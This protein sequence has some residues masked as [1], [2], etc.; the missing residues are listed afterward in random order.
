[1]PNN[2]CTRI[3]STAYIKNEIQVIP[4]PVVEPLPTI[5][6]TEEFYDPEVPFEEQATKRTE[7]FTNNIAAS[8]DIFSTLEYPDV[9]ETECFAE[10]NLYKQ[11]NAFD[12]TC[13]VE[14]EFAGEETSKYKAIALAYYNEATKG[15][16]VAIPEPEL[17][18]PYSIRV[19]CKKNGFKVW[20]YK[21]LSCAEPVERA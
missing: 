11:A 7:Q 9:P 1:M 16:C 14:D 15:S 4:A 19:E 5:D 13:T 2:T 3:N 17:L 6:L 12:F 20:S 18:G 10:M 8:V 21:G